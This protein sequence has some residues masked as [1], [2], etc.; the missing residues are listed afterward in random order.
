MRSRT[1]SRYYLQVPLTDHVENWSDDAF[2][3]ELRRRLPD[4]VA[5][6]VVTGPSFEKSIAPLRCFVAE[7]MRFGRLFLAGDAAHIV[8]P[9]GA[10]GLNL[11][12]S[13]VRYL[14]DGLREHYLDG[15]GAGLDAYSDRALARI[16][17]AERFSWWM[18]TMLH[19]FAED[20]AFGR[21]IHD[22]E[23]AY[24]LVLGRRA[25]RARRELRRPAVLTRRRTRQ[26][27]GNLAVFGYACSQSFG[28]GHVRRMRTRRVI[29]DRHTACRPSAPV[30]LDTSEPL[31]R[32]GGNAAARPD[33]DDAKKQATGGAKPCRP[34]EPDWPSWRSQG[35]RP[36]S[37]AVR[38]RRACSSGR[39]RPSRSRK[40]RR[41]ATRCWPA[42]RAASTTSRQD[43]GPFMTR[44]Q[45]ELAG[46][47]RARSRV[48]GALHGELR[49]LPDDLVDLVRHRPRR[50][51]R[52][53]PAF[54]EL[55]KLGTGEQKYLPWMQAT[56]VMAANK[57]ALEYL[58]EGA[59]INALTYDQLDRLGEGDGRGD[60]LAEVRLPGRARRG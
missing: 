8:P 56:Y 32:P 48:V 7:P 38:R 22:A 17:K 57:Q 30:K 26:V 33:R 54:I 19:T 45:A 55:G 40:R 21:R 15:S 3:D 39:P 49:Q 60:R 27:A 14:F 23:L 59:D 24:T 35:R 44:I 31:H 28:G 25:D 5:A 50:P 46:R 18:T 29:S 52:S 20:D 41:C 36:C 9:T 10:K 51:T 37:P 34:F 13:D 16:W 12:A 42:S 11:A 47:H 53:T 1:R 4:E 2:W 6:A 58:P 43:A